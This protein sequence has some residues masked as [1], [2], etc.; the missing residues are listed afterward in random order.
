MFK[1]ADGQGKQRNGFTSTKLER[2]GVL[3]LQILLL[4]GFSLPLPLLS[5]DTS[6]GFL[7]VPLRV[8]LLTTTPDS[9]R[10]LTG[11]VS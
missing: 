1:S 6:L 4:A 3:H 8:P 7:P 5:C 9:V 11:E 2:A 10:M